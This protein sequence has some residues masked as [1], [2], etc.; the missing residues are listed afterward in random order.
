MSMKMKLAQTAKRYS[1]QKWYSW[2]TGGI[3]FLDFFVPILPGASLVVA[4]SLMQ[5]RKWIV[6]A[7]MMTLG[8]TAGSFVTSFLFQLFGDQLLEILFPGITAS[9]GWD[10]ATSLVRDYGVF[11][12]FVMACVPVPIRTLT[13]VAA[14]S[15]IGWPIILIATLL[16]RSICFGTLSYLAS[17]APQYM[18]RL[19]WVQ[20]S[21]FMIEILK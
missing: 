6:F 5:P 14:I 18:L 2:W 8:A 16:G 9:S 20:R 21:P 12:L 1:S 10:G 11:A 7:I 13:V 4:S 3:L 19:K 15:G 17:R